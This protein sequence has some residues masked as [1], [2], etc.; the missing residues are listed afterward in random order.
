MTICVMGGGHGGLAVAAHLTLHQNDVHL[1]A[2][3]DHPGMIPQV[4]AAE[5]IM[6]EAMAGEHR[7]I[8]ARVKRIDTEV[9]EA[10]NTCESV[11]VVLPANV[12]ERY[13]EMIAKHLPDGRSVLLQPDKY[14]V[15]RLAAVMTQHGRDLHETLLMGSDSFLFIAKAHEG[16][17]IWLRGRKKSLEIAAFPGTRSAEAIEAVK[18]AYPEAVPTRSVLHTS[19]DSASSALHPTTIM[20]N[21]AKIENEGPFDC[22]NYEVSP[23]MGRMIDALDAERVRLAHSLGVEVSTFVE[24]WHRFYGLDGTNAYE[25]ISRSM[26]HE[27]QVSPSSSKHRYVAEDVP[28]GLVP[29]AELA[30]PTGIPMPNTEAMITAASTVNDTDYRANGATLEWMGLEGLTHGDVLRYVGLPAE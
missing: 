23:G 6:V 19:L 9:E 16:N 10:L 24:I 3:P 1:V 11:I 27:G 7:G 17:H 25:Q 4:R 22:D 15:L 2:L 28:F 12:R 14:G 30:L 26:S 18:L 29:L 21:L 20:L 13:F 8:F 5:G